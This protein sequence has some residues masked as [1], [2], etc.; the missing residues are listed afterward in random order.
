M[1]ASELMR[2]GDYREAESIIVFL[3]RKLSDSQWPIVA[4]GGLTPRQLKRVNEYI[5]ENLETSISIADLAKIAGVSCSHFCRA[6]KETC[7]VTPQ[8]YVQQ[9]RIAR[10]QWLMLETDESLAAIALHCGLSDQT[11][12][13]KV[14]RRL[15]GE[16]PAA[17]RRF[18]K[19]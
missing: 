17:W 13:C 14:F 7:D 15:V 9:R 2:Q 6:F 19:A 16:S 5:D 10:A 12:L 18:R 8:T 11:A 4:R 3:V 1:Q